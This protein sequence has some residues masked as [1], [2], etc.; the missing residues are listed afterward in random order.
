M[1]LSWVAIPTATPMP[2]CVDRPI[3]AAWNKAMRMSVGI[4]TGAN[5]IAPVRHFTL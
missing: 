2:S 4:M 3:I 5:L 1:V